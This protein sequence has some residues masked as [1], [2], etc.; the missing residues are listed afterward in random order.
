MLGGQKVSTRTRAHAREM[1]EQAQRT[2]IRD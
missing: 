2:G 1:L